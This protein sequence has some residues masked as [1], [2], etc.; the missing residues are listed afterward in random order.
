[1]LLADPFVAQESPQAVVANLEK[2]LAT[3]TSLQADFEQTYFGATV[4]APLKESGRL[5]LQKPGMMR[6]EYRDPSPQTI[7]FKDGL[8]QTY[9]PEE[10]QLIRQK[11]PEEQVETAILGLLTGRARLGERYLVE[12]TSFPG[13]AKGGRQVKLTPKEESETS[14]ILLEVDGRDWLIRRAVLFDWAGNKNEFAF[15]R[16]RTGARLDPGLF[17]IKVPPGCEIID[18]AAPR[19]K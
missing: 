4:S 16:V 8:L 1:M 11:L 5:Y 15:S 17:E 12:A 7:V 3:V 9:D 10:N 18:D 2:A 19:K 14:Y 13:A 6:W